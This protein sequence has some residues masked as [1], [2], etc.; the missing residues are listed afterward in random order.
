M[1]T[2]MNNMAGSTD[3]R[4]SVRGCHGFTVLE[5][6]IACAVAAVLLCIA[7]PSYQGYLHRVQR[8]SAI[9][10]LLAAA[11]CQ[12]R[13]YA[14]EAV[15]DTRRC[16]DSDQVPAYQFRMEPDSTANSMTFVVVAEPV[17]DQGTDPCGNLSLDQTGARAISGPEARSRK[18]WE[19]R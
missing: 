17:G 13:I 3:R 4:N 11:A 19:G 18:C 1:K 2:T 8:G 5:L 15:Y 16:L 14:A 6:M 7:I 10:V 12:E 9:E